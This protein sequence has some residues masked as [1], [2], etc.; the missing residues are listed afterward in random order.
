MRN[1]RMMKV[2]SAVLAT[3]LVMMLSTATVFAATTDIVKDGVFQNA[4]FINAGNLVDGTIQGPGNWTQLNLGDASVDAPY[5]HIIVKAAGGDTSAAQ[6]AVSDLYT[7]NLA[8]LGIT[9]T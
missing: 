9:L 7:F 1:S 4:G 2:L 6:I 5:L 8:D 3:V